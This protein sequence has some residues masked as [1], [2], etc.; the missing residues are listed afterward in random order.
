MIREETRSQASQLCVRTVYFRGPL[1]G[2][3]ALQLGEFERVR[4]KPTVVPVS[5]F[6][7]LHPAPF[8]YIYFVFI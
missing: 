2:E 1:R 8:L 4:W 5:F 6:P 7:N 3:A